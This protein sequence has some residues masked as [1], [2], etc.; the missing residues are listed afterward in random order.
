MLHIEG[1]LLSPEILDRLE[2]LPG[3]RDADFALPKNERL[4]DAIVR[5]WSEAKAQWQVFKSRM[6]RAP[7]GD[8]GT[9]DT[10]RFWLEPLMDLL[11]FNP[12]YQQQGEQIEQHNYHISHRDERPEG[13]TLHL[14]GFGLELDKRRKGVD[15]LSPHALLQEYLNRKEN[16]LYGLV[17]NGLY[18]RLLRDNARLRQQQ[19]VEWDLRQIFE[20][21]RFADFT[22]LY[23]LLHATRLRPRSDNPADCLLESYHQKG[24]E[25]GNRIR[26]GLRDAVV[27]ALQIMGT[28][29]LQHRDNDALRQ[30]IEAGTLSPEEYNQ[31]LRRLVYRLL[32][33]LVAE[34][35]ELIFPD[36]VT[37]TIDQRRARQIYRQHYSL[38]RLREMAALR[39]RCNGQA[40]NLWQ[41]LL[42]SFGI[43]ETET[44]GK[45]FGITPLDG[46][47]FNPDALGSLKNAALSNAALL[48]ALYHLHT[49]EDKKKGTRHR[50]NYRS[51]DVEELGSVYESLLDLHPYI[52]ASVSGARPSFSFI[53]ATERKTTGSYYTR[54]DLVAE[55]LR[56]ALEPVMAE[57]KAAAGKDL[58]KQAQALLSLKV[59][60]PSC[61]SGHFLLAAARRIS[62]ELARVR[63]GGDDQPPSI[64]VRACL[65]EVIEHCIYGVDL[66]PDAVELCQ[67]AL[68]L[69]SHYPGRPLSFLQHKIRCGNSLVGVHDLALLTKDLPDEAFKDVTGDDKQ[70][71]QMLRKQNKEWRTRKQLTLFGGEDLS[72]AKAPQQERAAAYRQ[73]EALNDD[74]LD[75]RR[76][77]AKAFEKLRN[78][79]NWL[80][81]LTACH[82]Y[83][84]AFFQ[85]LK[86]GERYIT[87][88][89]L[90]KQQNTV[91]GASADA[92]L[93]GRAYGLA[94]HYRFFHWPLEFPDVFE[95]GGFD[96]M[97]GNPPWEKIKLEEQQFF[98]TKDPTIANTKNKS[99]RKKLIEQ[100]IIENQFLWDEY[101]SAIHEAE[102]S[103]KFIRFSNQF[104]LSAKGDINTY[105][106]FTELFLKLKKNNVG[107]SGL[108]IP[109]GLVAESSSKDFFK[110]LMNSNSLE[111]FY[112]F[113]NTKKIFV[114]I[115][116][117]IKF[118]LLTLGKADDPNF[119]F[120]L[121]DV[122][123][124][125]D[126][127]RR[128]SVTKDEIMLINPNT[129]TCPIFRTK[130]D[131]QLTKKICSRLRIL[132]HDND[133]SNSWHPVFNTLYHMSNDSGEFKDKNGL[134]LRPLY[135]AKML[136][137]YDHR[138]STYENATVANINEG[139]L[140]QLTPEMHQDADKTVLSRYYIYE[141]Q[142]K[143]RIKDWDRK[144]FFAF[145][146][147]AATNNERTFI[148]S[149]VP[150]VGLG[151]SAPV[152]LFPKSIS[153]SKIGG[154]FANMNS[155]VY[156]YVGRQK[157]P[158]SNL[159]F[160]ILRQMPVLN[161]GDYNEEIL[162][163][164]IPSLLELVF[165]SWDIKA[166]A[167]D[168][169][170]EADEGLR[171]I[172]QQQWEDNKF[173]T[174]GH[175]WDIPE[176]S[177]AYPEICW[178]QQGDGCPLPPF[179]WDEDRR[180]RLRAELDAIYAR[181]YGLTRDEL[182][183]ILDPQD[184]YGPEFPG[185]T[186]RVLKDKEMRLY[187]EYRTE[188]LVLEAWDEMEHN[189]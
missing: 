137:N 77:K 66:N 116:D 78:D 110:Y 82:L 117:Y 8:S 29:F 99:Q 121:T 134:D 157:A 105:L 50:I 56:S 58:D 22:Q 5:A 26:D 17:S 128:F 45:P 33:L 113:V 187:G 41:E 11:D 18:L 96:L 44:Y 101:R 68:W 148:Y 30:A 4:A 127:M 36:E 43:F 10:R 180:A 135:E 54:H 129:E 71:A 74:T 92:Q 140:P 52:S 178:D 39:R 3:Q 150:F 174:G 13:I 16:F 111:S 14:V 61:G 181:L 31:Q 109:I 156:D 93:E 159:N 173:A 69:E 106:L 100:L 15:R 40:Q 6:E 75:G 53:Q 85:T 24:I 63:S 27:D 183:Y 55:L 170:R 147:I 19:Y 21:D 81:P 142:V 65:R 164:V 126:D 169:W 141:N 184:V 118:G 35:R 132:D 48:E 138:F 104:N 175:G 185:E 182:R 146:G 108:I 171:T 25:E 143:E 149:F 144:W 34:E 70:I 76:A 51:L 42:V 23:R 95:N 168:L 153:V 124:I 107:K 38:L 86:P 165:T 32:F 186:F 119:I 151:N 2:E 79:K 9:S 133:E 176:W 125:G 123:Q 89:L 20:E 47:L 166:F 103:S 67:V 49:Y 88:E 12:V 145:R 98:S 114:A 57:R 59:C 37:A 152:I 115:K 87:A 158:G 46:E 177:D 163:K 64:L 62:L 167:D 162:R 154:L 90:A 84:A 73:F 91:L 112:G 60:D 28:G 172:L 97:L 120:W 102:G 80:R 155:L 136:W 139:N 130:I 188:R 160:Y 1:S 161:T 122:S 72:A 179:K 189:S 7:E 131:A 94:T 83:T